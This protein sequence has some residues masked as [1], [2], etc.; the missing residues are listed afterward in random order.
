MLDAWI[1][2]SLCAHSPECDTREA[3]AAY[4]AKNPGN[5]FGWIYD[6]GEAE[7][8]GD[9]SGVDR[10]LEE[11]SRATTADTHYTATVLRFVDTLATLPADIARDWGSEGTRGVTAIGLVGSNLPA[12]GPL[13]R[14]CRAPIPATPRLHECLQIADLLRHAD[15]AGPQL[16]GYRIALRLARPDSEQYQ[17]I[18]SEEREFKW[19]QAQN[20]ALTQEPRWWHLHSDLDRYVGL[21]REHTREED[22]FRAQLGL[23]HLPTQPPADWIPAPDR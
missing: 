6:L 12:L 11:M 21:M 5:A 2:L 9:D 4:R 19:L 22:V 20:A 23:R 3:A 16:A 7:R 10:I 18:E 1:Y 15:T 13:L 17:R 8:G 14:A